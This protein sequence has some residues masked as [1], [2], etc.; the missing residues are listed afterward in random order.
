MRSQDWRA[1]APAGLEVVGVEAAGERVVV[2]VRPTA[3]D[4]ICP[5]CGSNSGQVHSRYERRMLDLPSH[6]RAV[7][8]RVLARR[9]RCG[10]IACPRQ[11]FAQRLGDEVAPVA[12]RRTSR[13]EEIVRCLGIT[14][15]GRPGVGVA[16]R[17]SMPV[18]KDTLLRAVRRRTTSLRGPVRVIGIDDWAWRRHQRYGTIICDLEQR[19]VVGLLA[20][21]EVGTIEAW[22]R[23]HPG[24]ATIARDRG[25]AYGQ[26]ASMAT[27]DAE[28]VADRWHLMENASAAFL[29]AVRKSMPTVRRALGSAPIDPAVL[30]VA[31]RLQFA[32]YERRRTEAQEIR[33]MS[34]AGAPIKEIVRRTGRSRK[35][36][37]AIVRGGADEVFRPRVSTL[38]PHLPW[39]EVTWTDGCRNGAELWRRLRAAGF[40]GGLRVVTE[41]ASRRRRAE[42]AGGEIRRRP[43]PARRLARLMLDER[44]H[45]PRED[46]VIVAAVEAAAPELAAVRDLVGRFQTMIRGRNPEA[47][48]GWL[49]EASHGM[50]A[51]F[52]RGLAA[53][54]PAVAAALVSEWSNG[55]TEGKIT[56]LKLLRRQM[57]GRGSL[58]TLRAR[59]L[60]AEELHAM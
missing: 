38:D 28:Q 35:L 6:G 37:R 11:T 58:E 10:T 45:L 32:A 22:L 34:N 60:G 39:L 23:E 3:T 7:E 8:L 48:A 17:L 33:G 40:R 44:A 24:M 15:G 52:S 50:L 19:R 53:D 54:Q 42:Q 2:T 9:V 56:K 12:A 27:P 41:W 4:G 26:A 30:T 51:A 57:Y 29:E 20:D 43:L 16:K 25:G 1:I 14:L 55:Q 21:R 18:S 31:E 36:V 5:A 49:S 46:A 13:L 47:L 59:L